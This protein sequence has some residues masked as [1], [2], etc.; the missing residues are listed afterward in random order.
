MLLNAFDEVLAFH[1]FDSW[2]DFWF[3][4]VKL[5]FAQ[6]EQVSHSI[7]LGF[8]WFHQAEPVFNKLYSFIRNRES[9]LRNIGNP[10]MVFPVFIE[11]AVE[12]GEECS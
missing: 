10:L 1:W 12:I 3:Y 4:Q 2:F 9:L 6:L 8:H 5:G 11:T 7:E